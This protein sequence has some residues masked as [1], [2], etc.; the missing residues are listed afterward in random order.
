[1]II[2]RTPFRVSFVGGGS[3]LPSFYHKHGGAVLSTTINKYMH[4]SVHPYFNRSMFSLKYSKNELVDSVNSINHPIIKETLNH[5]DI[6]SGIEVTTTADIPSGTGLGSSSAF[7]VGLLNA[8]YAYKS[9]LVTK[10]HLAREACMIEIEK[11]GSPIGKQDQY[12]SSFGGLNAIT[13]EKDGEVKVNPVVISSSTKKALEENLLLF[14]TKSERD[15][16]HVLKEQKQVI[17]SNKKIDVL[18][19][20]V[21]LVPDLNDAL[22]RGDL[23]TFGELLHKNWM[24]KKSI[25]PV[26]ST[27]NI[28]R[29]YEIAMNNGALGGKLLGAGGGGFLLFYCE[30]HKQDK[31]RKALSDLSEMKFA[32][33]NYG[34]KLIYFTEDS[35][36]EEGFFGN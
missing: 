28:D 5:L 9:R 21:D 14:Y 6:K 7:T 12:A 20:M 34:T 19:S 33:D 2:T 16:N 31:L 35:V 10:E 25:A 8:L 29:Y 27:S 22:T 17:E 15:A 11:V 30:K 1:M 3:D 24:L 23:S 4:V 13:F 18:K 36:E 32:F 26:I